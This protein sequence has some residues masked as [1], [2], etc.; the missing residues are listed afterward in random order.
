M[1]I[2]HLRSITSRG[3]SA[4]TVGANAKQARKAH[5]ISRRFW[6]IFDSLSA[7]PATTAITETGIEVKVAKPIPNDASIPSVGGQSL[8]PQEIPATPPRTDAIISHLDP[9]SDNA[10]P[11][12][13][14]SAMRISGVFHPEESRLGG[15]M[16]GHQHIA[17]PAAT[18]TMS[19]VFL[20]INTSGA[21]R[22]PP[23]AR[24]KRAVEFSRP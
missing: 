7:T 3:V 1:Q 16:L 20:C 13:V 18:I 19:S 9:P 24:R 22:L 23:V 4:T 17:E 6:A 2:S 21:V 11:R 12:P 15:M 8:K 5:Q 14:T 10:V